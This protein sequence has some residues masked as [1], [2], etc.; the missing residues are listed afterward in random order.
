MQLKLRGVWRVIKLKYAM[1][2]YYIV[3]KLFYPPLLWW[4]TSICMNP[5]YLAGVAAPP[6]P[7]IRPL[8]ADTQGT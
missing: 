6:V 7:S 8:V 4:E 3:P 2:V 1:Q 5:V